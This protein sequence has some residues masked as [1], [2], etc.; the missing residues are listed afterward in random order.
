MK[1]KYIVCILS[2]MALAS[3]ENQD[4]VYPDYEVSACYFPYQTPIRTL[5]LGKYDQGNNEND[6][7]QRFEIG[8]TMG[9]VYSNEED[10]QVHFELDNSLL[11]NVANVQ[12]L[13]TEF[14]TIEST[15]P[16]TIPAGSTKGRISIQLNNA[17]FNDPMSF[18]PD[19][20]VNYVIPL[21]IT[22]AENLDTVLVGRS[23]LE[24][25]NKVNPADWDQLPKDYTLFGIKFINK[26]HG[27]YLRRGIDV[28]TDADGNEVE[29]VYHNEFVVKDEVVMLTTSGNQ[30]VQLQNIV[31]RGG[32][33]SPGNLNME[34][35]FGTDNSCRII[36]TEGDPYNISGSGMYVEDA[37]EWGG[38]PR[39]V[40]Y[41]D[42]SYTDMANNETHQVKDTLVIRDRA[43][44]FE[45]FTV[46]FND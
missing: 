10:R 2:V 40:I 31:R 38:L 4:I 13:S 17:F 7:N 6:N 20:E 27:H 34:L 5:I 16:V 25:P 21:R 41:L 42:Y 44:V 18:A 14:Y 29:N 45:E 23:S 3:C 39:D 46:E 28:L 19:N 24:A 30:A 37:D 1:L 33:N 15:S 11:D 9:G 32:E 35:V 26:Y 12:T 8:V 36:S 43:V 22:E